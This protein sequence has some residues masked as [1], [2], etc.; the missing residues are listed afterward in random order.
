M[1]GQ[2]VS[3]VAL[4]QDLAKVDAARPDGLLHPESLGIEVSQLA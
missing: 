2:E 1:L 4:A 3:W